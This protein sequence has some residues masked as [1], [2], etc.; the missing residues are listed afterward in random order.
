M[1]NPWS[2]FI[3]KSCSSDS[4]AL[5][6]PYCTSVLPVINYYHCIFQTG[7]QFIFSNIICSNICQLYISLTQYCFVKIV[8]LTISYKMNPPGNVPGV[9]GVLDIIG[10]TNRLFDTQYDDRCLFWNHIWILVHKLIV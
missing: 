4:S 6:Y 5:C 9:F 8:L 7:I 1:S 3:R 10:H 2:R